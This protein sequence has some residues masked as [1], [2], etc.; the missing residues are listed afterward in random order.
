MSGADIEDRK[1]KPFGGKKAAAFKPGGGRNPH[2]PNTA[3]GEPRKP[4]GTK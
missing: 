4:R 3:K 2:S 1:G